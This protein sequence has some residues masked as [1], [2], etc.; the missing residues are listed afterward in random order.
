MMKG[1]DRDE[2]GRADGRISANK[3]AEHNRGGKG[4]HK[5]R[6]PLAKLSGMPL[7]Q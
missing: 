7:A 3:N 5:D 4:D 1:L 6:M 2:T